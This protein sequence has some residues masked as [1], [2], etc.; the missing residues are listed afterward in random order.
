M[1]LLPAARVPPKN[2]HTQPI[3]SPNNQTTTQ[4]RRAESSA[5]K[6]N[7]RASLEDDEYKGGEEDEGLQAVAV[8]P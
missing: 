6:R 4:E 1:S 5:Y 2:T 7:A 8:N 3:P